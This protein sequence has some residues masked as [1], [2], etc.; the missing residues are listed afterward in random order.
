[1]T[2]REFKQ[3]KEKAK[4]SSFW[5]GSLNL[6]NTKKGFES[7]KNPSDYYIGVFNNQAAYDYFYFNFSKNELTID[8]DHFKLRN[9]FTNINVHYKHVKALRASLNQ[10]FK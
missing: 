4:I 7:I 2:T 5:G 6:F 10:N 8:G 1:M 9:K 3:W